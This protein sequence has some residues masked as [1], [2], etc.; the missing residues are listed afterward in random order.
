MWVPL[1]LPS[2]FAYTGF[3]LRREMLEIAS[4]CGIVRRLLDVKL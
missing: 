2:L 3:V 1:S 4:N